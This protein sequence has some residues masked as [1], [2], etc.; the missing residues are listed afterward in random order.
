[1][2][3]LNAPKQRQIFFLMREMAKMLRMFQGEA[4]FCENVTLTQFTILDHV[5]TKGRL[6]LSELHG[7]LAVEKSTTTRLV[8]PL[9]KKGLLA[10]EKSPDDSRAIELRLTE[11]GIDTHRKVWEC[12]ADNT[13]K[14]L[15]AIPEVERDQVIQSLQ[16]FIRAFYTCCGPE[17]GCT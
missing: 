7:L 14:M 3:D 17:T 2:I 10:R 15:E 6:R 13:R 12:I 4:I 1:M 9:V 5:D 16:V 8:D 11:D